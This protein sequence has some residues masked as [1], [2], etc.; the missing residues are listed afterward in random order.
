MISKNWLA[1]YGEQE[2]ADVVVVA[3]DGSALALAVGSSV[4]CHC[5]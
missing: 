1:T 5:V 4:G 2:V 3:T